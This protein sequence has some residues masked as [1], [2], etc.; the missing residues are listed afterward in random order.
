MSL[1]AVAVLCDAVSPVIQERMLGKHSVSAAELM[2][3]T[4]LIAFIGIVCAWAASAEYSVYDELIASID[5]PAVFLLMLCTYGASSWAGV[6]FML[7][8]IEVHGSAVGV[9]VGTL[10]KVVTIVISFIWW[11]KPF[12]STFAV[13]GA[14]V[15]VSI[16]LNQHAK[17]LDAVLCSR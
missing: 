13:S 17:K 6:T 16:V 12:S 2:V 11:S 14:C 15:L 4:N 3:R 1:L 5:N 9:A 8:L 10:R 7:A